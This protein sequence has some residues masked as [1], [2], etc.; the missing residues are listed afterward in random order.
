MSKLLTI[1]VPSYNAEKYLEYNMD[2]LCHEDIAEYLEVIVVDDGSKD[3]TAEIIDRYAEKYSDIIVPV[4]KENG[5]HGSGINTGIRLATGKYF[6]VIDADDWADEDDLRN[7]VNYIKEHDV[8]DKAGLNTEPDIIAGGFY[9]VYGHDESCEK[10]EEF[11]EPFEGV[12]YNHVYDFNE[13]AEKAYIKMHSL[14]IKT[15]ILKEHNIK[16]DEHCFYVDTEYILYPIPYVETV[17]FLDDHL[18]RYSIEREGQ[19][20]NPKQMMKN[21]TQFDHVLSE[22]FKFY[23]RVKE[24]EFVSDKKRL[25]IEHL[26]ARIYAGRIK[27]LLWD[28]ISSKTR[29]ELVTM[30][31]ELKKKFPEI[32]R[33]NINKA[34]KAMRVSGYLLY[35]PAAIKMHL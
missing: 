35:Y 3:G 11:H 20:M 33:A 19:S 9:W 4:H 21:K 34:V 12:K 28:K 6:K 23:E 17:V 27:I 30:D 13:I 24:M 29:K 25:Y 32:Y 8:R 2:S 5:G 7:L 14:T 26:I 31:Q 15:D 10:K 16:I 1:V 18:Y 22:L